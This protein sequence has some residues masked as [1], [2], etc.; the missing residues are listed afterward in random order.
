MKNVQGVQ[1][2]FNLE[3]RAERRTWKED[4]LTYGIK[5][6]NEQSKESKEDM[7]KKE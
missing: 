1:N 6:H 5:N 4:C 2:N 3:K 7:E